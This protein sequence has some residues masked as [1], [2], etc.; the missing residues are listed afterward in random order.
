MDN[1]RA[2]ARLDIADVNVG[3][4]TADSNRRARILATLAKAQR[5]G[6]DFL[7][8]AH[9]LPAQDPG[10]QSESSLIRAVMR[11]RDATP[12]IRSGECLRHPSAFVAAIRPAPPPPVTAMVVDLH[13]SLSSPHWCL[14]VLSGTSPASVI[15]NVRTGVSAMMPFSLCVGGISLGALVDSILARRLGNQVARYGG[16]LLSKQ[17]L[18]ASVPDGRSVDDFRCTHPD[19][20]A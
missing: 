5:D 12:Y 6:L 4:A 19:S 9:G 10:R 15:E 2:H 18:M 16:A 11:S 17:E 3:G 20:G 7:I 8:F 1:V 13:D 14:I